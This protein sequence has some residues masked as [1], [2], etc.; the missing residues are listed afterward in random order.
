MLE[1]RAKEMA[2]KFFD[3]PIAMTVLDGKVYGAYIGDWKPYTIPATA[4]VAVL[5][6]E[7]KLFN[8]SQPGQIDGKLVTWWMNKR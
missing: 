2:E 6:I 4:A 5:A 1:Q 3:I 7:T 8:Y